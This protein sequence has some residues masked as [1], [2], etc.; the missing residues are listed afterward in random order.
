MNFALVSAFTVVTHLGLAADAPAPPAEPGKQQFSE[1]QKQALSRLEAQFEKQYGE[2]KDGVRIGLRAMK[3]SYT[4]NQR[5]VLWCTF[6]AP[7]DQP[8][9]DAP[10]DNF[11]IV[12]H[13]D[14]TTTKL[15]G[16]WPQ[17]RVFGASWSGGLSAVAR[18]EVLQPGEHKAQWK[19]G[20]WESAV[21]TFRITAE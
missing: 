14:G 7:K 20:K 19:L 9:G 3:P 4:A 21:A 15:P 18:G 11:V 8:A 12:T 13:P 1:A 2:R 16:N 17:S 5:I 6:D 10:G